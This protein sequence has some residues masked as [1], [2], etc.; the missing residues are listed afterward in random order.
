MRIFFRNKVFDAARL[1]SDLEHMAMNGYEPTATLGFRRAAEKI[2]MIRIVPECDVFPSEKYGTIEY[3]SKKYRLKIYDPRF[4]DDAGRVCLI[5][6]Y[7][8]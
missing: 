7:I 4:T 5:I 3:N 1:T 2:H 8:S 6:A